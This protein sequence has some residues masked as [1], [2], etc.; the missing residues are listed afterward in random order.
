M[1]I[2]KTGEET[3]KET[4]FRKQRLKT[5]QIFENF[6]GDLKDEMDWKTATESEKRIDLGHL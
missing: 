2:F 3:R 4:E 6:G 1:H 5:G